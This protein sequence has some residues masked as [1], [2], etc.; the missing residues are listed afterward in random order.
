MREKRKRK[1]DILGICFS[2][3]TRGRILGAFLVMVKCKDDVISQKEGEN[4][5]KTIKRMSFLGLLTHIYTK[6]NFENIMEK[7]Q[8]H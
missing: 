4:T 5:E 2:S 1:E 8:R 6:M 7:S 3:S